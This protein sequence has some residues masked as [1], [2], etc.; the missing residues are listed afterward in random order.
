MLMC[1]E[2]VAAVL[3]VPLALGA[4]PKL[5]LG[6]GEFRSAADRAAVPR[7]FLGCRFLLPSRRIDGKNSD[8]SLSR[9]AVLS[10]SGS[11][12]E[13]FQRTGP[14]EIEPQIHERE[15]YGNPVARRAH[16]KVVKLHHNIDQRHIDC[17]NRQKAHQVYPHIGETQ[18]KGEKERQIQRVGRD[19][20]KVAEHEIRHEGRHN[21]EEDAEKQVEVKAETTPA[22]FEKRADP[23]VKEKSHKTEDQ[24]FQ[25]T[26]AAARREHEPGDQAPDLPV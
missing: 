18:G 12:Q 24:H 6:V 15:Q 23:V 1:V 7:L 13:F 16:D 3:M 14:M 21:V 9:T 11:L 20:H 5:Q 22:L 26:S 25:R 4:I 19:Q 10:R 17:A 2:M 8:S